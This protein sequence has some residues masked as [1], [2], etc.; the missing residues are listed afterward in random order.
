MVLECCERGF[1]S[2]PPSVVWGWMWDPANARWFAGYGPVAAV[3]SSKVDEMKVGAVRLVETSDG[4]TLQEKILEV[5]P[6]RRHRYLLTGIAGAFG[7]LVTSGDSTWEY[8]E[9]DGRTEMTWTYRFALT[10]PLVW[11]LARIVTALFA[12]A[13]RRALANIAS[14]F[15][16]ASRE[17]A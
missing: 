5:D 3:L 12:A 9:V 17:A 16:K 15:E 1:A 11:P 4:M 10:T 8:Q 2:A 7:L 13:Q 6:P 14:A